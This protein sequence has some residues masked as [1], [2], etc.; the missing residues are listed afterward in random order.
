MQLYKLDGATD[1]ALAAAQST[2]LMMMEGVAMEPA[3]LTFMNRPHL[4]AS[5]ENEGVRM[6]IW[7]GG[8]RRQVWN[9]LLAA[10]L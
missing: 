5:L 1:K 3:P 4:D 7:Q 6:P 9:A 8:A 10:A 2:W